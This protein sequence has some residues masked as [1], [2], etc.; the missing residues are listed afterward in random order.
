MDGSEHDIVPTAAM[1][2]PGLPRA[3]AM[4]RLVG[5]VAPGIDVVLLSVEIWTD[6]IGI[7]LAGTGTAADER[8]RQWNAE[9]EQWASAGH[10][11][12]PPADPSTAL[13]DGLSVDL[14][15]AGGTVF[16]RVVASAGGEWTAWEACLV[17]TPGA[18]NG[19]VRI[20][21][22]CGGQRTSIDVEAGA[23]HAQ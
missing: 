22:D 1:A 20:S 16:R 7:R 2:G 3:I 10:A 8:Q 6:R 4:N 19:R 13:I 14:A 21:L 17:F 5:S 9:T 15:D 12:P 23:P 11:G 18:R